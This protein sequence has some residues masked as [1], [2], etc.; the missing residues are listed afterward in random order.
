[1]RWIKPRNGCC[2]YTEKDG[3]RYFIMDKMNSRY[4]HVE[5]KKIIPANKKIYSTYQQMHDDWFS[6]LTF[7]KDVEDKENHAM[8]E[9]MMKT[10]NANAGSDYMRTLE[11]DGRHYAFL[12]REKMVNEY[13]E[14]EV[15]SYDME[16]DECKK[17]TEEYLEPKGLFE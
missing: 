5:R 7:P 15:I 9:I 10:Q 4:W 17:W 6:K 3:Y 13:T 12:I 8:L 1:M 16:F 2:L 11:R 14:N